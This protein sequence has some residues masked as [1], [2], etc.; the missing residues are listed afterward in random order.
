MILI[1]SVLAKCEVPRRPRYRR[2]RGIRTFRGR[3]PM[4][5]IWIRTS[6][7]GF[8]RNLFPSM[9]SRWAAGGAR[10]RQVQGAS[11]RADPLARR[12]MPREHSAHARDGNAFR[13]ITKEVTNGPLLGDKRTLG[14]Q[15]VSV[16]IDPTRTCRSSA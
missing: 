1:T 13:T 7:F 14:G 16:A 10:M 6:E 4:E 3:E 15:R 11:L 2:Y 9:P 5:R 8:N 12:M